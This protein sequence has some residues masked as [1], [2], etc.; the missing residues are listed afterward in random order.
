[1]IYL[2]SC[3]LIYAV[4]D[5]GERGRAA[6]QALAD[7]ADAELVVSPLVVMECITGPLKR[8]DLAL[9]DYYRSTL[10]SA[11]RAP[12]DEDVF[13]RAAELRARHALSTPDA[14]HLAA[15]QK[16]GCSALWTN[17]RRL[18]RAAHGLAVAIVAEKL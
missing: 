10:A 8:G 14:L 9:V 1:M 13:V 15:A 12:F 16:A 17:D 18:E 4:E 6:R 7:H 5:E 3:I 11:A 2:D